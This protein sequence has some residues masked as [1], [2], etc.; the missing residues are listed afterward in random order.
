MD[1]FV[2]TTDIAGFLAPLDQALF[3]DFLKVASYLNAEGHRDAPAVICMSAL[4]GHLRKLSKKAGIVLTT[5]D[6]LPKKP[7]AL[8]EEL[9]AKGA[10]SGLDRDN[11][12]GWLDL[13]R[14]AG[15]GGSYRYRPNQVALLLEGVRRFLDQ[16]PA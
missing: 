3:S 13:R 16:Y 8:N 10:Y 11:V 9:A 12:S 2:V 5:D 6:G 4:E 1:E 7:A 15:R 14:G